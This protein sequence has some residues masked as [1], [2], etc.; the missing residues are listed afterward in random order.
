MVFIIWPDVAS[1]N[2][3]TDVCPRHKDAVPITP[4]ASLGRRKTPGV[5]FFFFFFSHPLLTFWILI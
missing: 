4:G 5:R 2:I 1:G 3:S